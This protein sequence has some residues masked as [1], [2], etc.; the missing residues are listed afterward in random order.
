MTGRSKDTSLLT[1]VRAVR[2]KNNRFETIADTVTC[3][4]P[5]TIQWQGQP[6]TIDTAV[7]ADV[8]DGGGSLTVGQGA[9]T[10][11]SKVGHKRE[12]AA[13]LW[14]Y[15]VDVA[16]LVAGHVALDHYPRSLRLCGKVETVMQANDASLVKV[17]VAKVEHVA[18]PPSRWKA[19]E[20]LRAMDAFIEAEG[21]WDTTGCFHRAGVYDIGDQRLLTRA[22]DIGRHNCIDR[23]A[24]WSLMTGTALSDKVLLVSARMTSSLCAKII[25]AGFPIIVSRSAVTTAAIKMA[26]EAQVTLLGFARSQEHRFTVFH[27][28]RCEIY[29][30]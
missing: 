24:G 16:T 30:D 7:A 10:L 12:G 25:R 13:T 5:Y 9:V 21:L 14:A 8:V 2:F 26:E 4:T 18:K 17:Q 22:E 11:V 3:E 20:V 6:A 27:Q 28:G 23:L 19:T 1:N 29:H 15:P